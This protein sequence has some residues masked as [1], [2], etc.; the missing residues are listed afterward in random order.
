MRD[1]GAGIVSDRHTIRYNV[2]VNDRNTSAPDGVV[3]VV[4]GPA[5][6][7]PVYNNTLI[8]DAPGPAM[9]SSN[10]PRRRHVP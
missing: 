1:V 2:S 3:S 4:C 9:V 6:R 5:A 10:G 7:T 8:I